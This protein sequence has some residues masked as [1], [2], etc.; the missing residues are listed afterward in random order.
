[1]LLPQDALQIFCWAVARSILAGC[2]PVSRA[3]CGPFLSWAPAPIGFAAL[4]SVAPSEASSLSLAKW[5]GAR[6]LSPRY[7]LSPWLPFVRLDVSSPLWPFAPFRGQ[8]LTV[9]LDL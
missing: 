8:R 2:C 3:T 4:A 1:M 7:G 6:G 5:V 9:C